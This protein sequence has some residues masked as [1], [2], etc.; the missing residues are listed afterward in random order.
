MQIGF[1]FNIGLTK[2]KYKIKKKLYEKVD[3]F[4]LDFQ[5]NIPYI[6]LANS[7]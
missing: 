2:L 6:H 7:F 1:I 5:T 3:L 4:A